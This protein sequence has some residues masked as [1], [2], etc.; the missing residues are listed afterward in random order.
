LPK[1]QPT[2]TVFIVDDSELL[3]QH[4]TTLIEK[5]PGT[6]IV[7]EA[8]LGFEA[9]RGIRRL[10]PSIVVLDISIPGGSGLEVLESIQHD[11]HHPTFIV[12]TNFAHDRYRVR[13]RELGANHFYDKLDEIDQVLAVI[14]RMASSD[15]IVSR[16][17]T[18][19]P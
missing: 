4:L 17:T 11:S 6:R 12:L 3:R 7:G 2:P 16:Q 14:S 1:S 13:C 8:E 10:K 9:I 5:I 18:V 19:A 15:N